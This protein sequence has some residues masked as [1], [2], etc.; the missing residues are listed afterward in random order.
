MEYIQVL[1]LFVLLLLLWNMLQNLKMLKDRESLRLKKPL[2]LISVLLPARNEEKNIKR[3][4]C[5]LLKQ[6]YSLLEIIVL[7]DNSNDRTFEIAKELSQRDKKIQIIRGEKLPSG[8]NGKNWA[9]HQLSQKAKGEWLL[10]TD[11]DTI[12]KPHSISTALAAA[13]NSHSVFV[14]C[15]PGLIA[16]TWSEKLYM[17]IIHFAFVAL[18][19]FKLINYSKNSRIP[20]GIGPFMLIKK[21]FYFSCGGYEVLKKEIVDDMALA[22]VVMENGGK[23]SVI[24]GT[25][26]MDV[27]FYTSFKEVWNGFSKNSYEAIGGHPHYVAGIFFVCYFLFIYPYLAFWGAIESHQNYSFPLC[28]I[29]VISLI[30]LILALRFNTSILY[31]LLHPLSVIFALLILLNSLRLSIFKKRFEWKERLYPIE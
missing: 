6:N 14:T 28:Q 18:L 9:C 23:I 22:K 27:R 1:T 25:K 16:K 15:V 8:W 11:A 17:S 31:G 24:D 5:S 10:F 20:V 13:Q 29:I 21:D 3:C 2:P 30:K 12:H 26:F 4:V 7:D 19:P